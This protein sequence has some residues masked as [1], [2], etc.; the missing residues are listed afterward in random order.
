[1]LHG[2]R[3]FLRMEEQPVNSLDATVEETK[4]KEEGEGEIDE[5]QVEFSPVV[6]SFV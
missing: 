1:M 5:R 6:K 2:Y 3:T 4:T